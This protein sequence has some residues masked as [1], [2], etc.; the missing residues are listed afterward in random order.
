L[1]TASRRPANTISPTGLTAATYNGTIAVTAT[2]A[3][4]SPQTISVT[5][6]VTSITSSVNVASIT[7]SASG[8]SG[9]IAPGEIITIK[10]GGL[11]P[12]VGVSF[13]VD[14]ATGMVDS[15][16]AGTRVFFG[17]FRAPITYT[18]GGQVNAT[19]PYEIAGQSQITMQV[20][21]QGNFSAGVPLPVASAAPGVF[22]FN[23]TG[24]GQ[25]LA[26]NQDGTFNGPATP[27]A[28]GSYVT[29]YFTGGG[30][31]NPPGVTGS[32]NGSTLKWLAQNINVTVRGVP[33]VVQFD[34]ASPGFFDGVG[35]FY[36]QLAR[37][38][39]SGAAQ[40]LI[41][42]V[43]GVSSRSPAGATLAVH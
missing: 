22:T 37:N 10:G 28:K 3:T 42:V 20:S 31:T 13:S 32:V 33:A 38:T 34:G 16:L 11:G 26:A 4:N 15:T 8:A 14:L 40:P 12:A 19:V 21:Y 39:P 36:I 25:A 30:Q 5:L 2:G 43:G 1:P 29:I 18:S 9:A 41:V 35:L 27:A 17:G 24:T 7:N 6:T 23:S